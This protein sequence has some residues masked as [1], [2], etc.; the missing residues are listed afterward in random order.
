MHVRAP[1]VA[2]MFYPADP[3]RLASQVSE[4]LAA[5]PV[6]V[7]GHPRALIVPHAGYVYSGS[8][9][10]T[11]YRTV[12]PS[13]T[14]RVVLVGPSH[15]LRFAGLAVPD[16]DVF[17]TPLGDV[18]IASSDLP[19][20]AAAHAREHSLEVQVPFLQTVL[21]EFDLL[22]IAVGDATSGDV[23]E[24]LDLHA[25]ERDT[26]IVI[27]SDLSH[28][29]RY[30]QAAKKDRTTAERIERQEGEL[31]D[32]DAACGLRGI[33]GGLL[34]AR[35]HDLE[36]HLLDLRNSGDTQGDRSRVVGYGA[37]WIGPTG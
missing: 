12:D 13:R 3:I 18:P 30:E 9:A 19:V 23:A 4:F 34:Y 22:P 31:L 33:Q 6:P 36:V 28:Y 37:F 20:S 5:A 10:A 32:R 26:L 11:G 17:R 25:D 35:R 2:G 7:D 21:G 24:A 8:I 29:L 14:H 1:A 15:Y 16:A 27:S